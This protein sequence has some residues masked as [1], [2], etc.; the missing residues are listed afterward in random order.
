M[1]V[2]CVKLLFRFLAEYIEHV[3]RDYLVDQ[4]L[5]GY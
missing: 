3:S 4:S 2:D 5:V 1:Q